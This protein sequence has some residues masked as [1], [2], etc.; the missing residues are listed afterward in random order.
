MARFNLFRLTDVLC[1]FFVASIFISCSK[2]KN[3]D[4]ETIKNEPLTSSLHRKKIKILFIGNSFS[5]QATR[6]LPNIAAENE[7]TV[8]IGRAEISNGSLKMHWNSILENQLD[9][10]QGKSYSGKSLQE[11]LKSENWD[12]VSLQQVSNYSCDGNSYRPYIDSL[13]V[14]IRARLPK[15]EIVFHQTWAYRSDAKAF[16]KTDNGSAKSE[17]EMYE[18]L[19]LVYLKMG[20]QFGVRVVPTGDAF[21]L[22]SSHPKWKFMPDSNFNYSNAVYPALPN[23]AN[24]LHIGYYYDSRKVLLFDP[25]HCNTAGCFLGS[26]IWYKF[27]F[28][29][30]LKEIHFKPSDLSVEFADYLRQTAESV[31]VAKNK[32]NNL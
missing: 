26:L 2:D 29:K 31:V 16:S 8:I 25:N 13:I 9:P 5:N 20:Q 21:S 3:I 32:S 6:Y 4:D 15:T 18:K 12:I 24:S 10:S 27:L 19:H 7:D 23:E 22:V 14:Y 28:T 11:M 1:L 30:E 17:E